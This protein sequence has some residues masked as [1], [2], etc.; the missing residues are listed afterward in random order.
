MSSSVAL[1]G[2]SG[3]RCYSRNTG[4]LNDG[5]N[6]GPVVRPAVIGWIVHWSL[7][8]VANQESVYTILLSNITYFRYL[9]YLV[10]GLWYLFYFSR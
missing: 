4:E 3:Q 5:L 8:P 7:V 9:W 2:N 1:G 10:Y 6:P